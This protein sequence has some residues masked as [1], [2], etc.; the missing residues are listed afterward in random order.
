MAGVNHGS[1]SQSPSPHP[2]NTPPSALP[3]SLAAPTGQ[4]RKR[5]IACVN[6]HKNKKKC[7][8]GSTC[9]YCAK[10]ERSC[11][12]P[13]TQPGKYRTNG[14]TAKRQE[15][16]K[17]R[18]RLQEDQR[19]F[20]RLQMLKQLPGLEG[21]PTIGGQ[22]PV[23]LQQQPP[24]VQQQQQ[25]P[26]PPMQQQ[27]QPPPVIVSVHGPI[28]IEDT[29]P[30][31]P[32][33]IA[34][35][36]DDLYSK[37]PPQSLPTPSSTAG[38]SSCLDLDFN[39]DPVDFGTP[40]PVSPAEGLFGP[41]TPPAEGPT[42]PQSPVTAH[43]Q[44]I[45]QPKFDYDLGLSLLDDDDLAELGIFPESGESVGAETGSGADDLTK[46]MDDA[47]LGATNLGTFSAEGGMDLPASSGDRADADREIERLLNAGDE[48]R[49]GACDSGSES[50]SETTPGGDEDKEEAEERWRA[51]LPE[52]DSADLLV[53]GDRGLDKSL[54]G[55]D[56]WMEKLFFELE[57]Q[58]PA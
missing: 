30:P 29:P 1:L 46:W 49:V 2:H 28:V 15:T 9:D 50:G 31:S 38:D 37:S 33:P 45:E 3:G 4:K 58:M 40:S 26:H 10:T 22:P 52:A 43:E 54:A 18:R 7:S 56:K 41:T 35:S 42:T 48:E 47:L 21:Y 27:V 20:V 51:N 16:V 23:L 14:L 5:I 55:N 39:L 25:L 57:A 17:E 34:A 32:K 19:V 36:D 53:R 8:T 24:W 13:D 11:V 6:C 12:Y 44:P